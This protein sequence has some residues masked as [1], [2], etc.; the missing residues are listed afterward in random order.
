MQVAENHKVLIVDD[1]RT[2]LN[3]LTHIL[4]QDY[5]VLVAKDGATGIEIAGEEKPDLILLDIIMEDIDGYTVFSML[6]ASE[7]TK[8]I[9]VI[10]ITGLNS[11]EDMEKG[12]ALGAVDYIS[13]PFSAATVREKVFRQLRNDY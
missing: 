3:V 5:T 7:K 13:K 8:D 2:N 11:S 10:F 9:P 4:R 1:E 12:L 6:K